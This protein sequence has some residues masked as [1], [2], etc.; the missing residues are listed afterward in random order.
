MFTEKQKQ[1]L[2]AGL[3]GAG[4]LLFLVIY[5]NMMFFTEQKASAQASLSKANKEITD[6]KKEIAQMDKF[7]NDEDERRRLE[8]IV[9]AA[10][11][12]L[13]SSVDAIDFID[14]IR[15]G[16]QRTGI[17]FSSISPVKIRDRDTYR[18]IPYQIKGASRY[19]EFG[20]F[21]NLVECHP[22]RFMRVN[23]FSI[24]NDSKR[25]SIHPVNV[26]IST[27]MFQE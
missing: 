13:P 5:V 14:I 23:S 19:H 11:N 18:E 26:E 27:F 4:F 15:E 10:R 6:F 25:P 9:T 17:S 7:L 1:A 24:V 16:A 21:L 8:E 20:Q 3:L 12:R 2:I 22:D